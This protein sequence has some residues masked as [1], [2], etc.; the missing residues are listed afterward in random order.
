MKEEI[1]KPMRNYP[2]ETEEYW[3]R[4]RSN[5]LVSGVSRRKYCQAQ[6]VNYDR[7]NYWFKKLFSHEEA[8]PLGKQSF[9]KNSL[10][11]PVRLAQTKS[12]AEPTPLCT[13]TLKNGHH[14]VIH[15]ER[16]LSLLLEHWRS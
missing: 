11:L 12:N 2:D 13:L 1:K 14:L 6:G 8:T 10:L 4:H 9:G 15:H 3:K 7:F 16:A 5:F